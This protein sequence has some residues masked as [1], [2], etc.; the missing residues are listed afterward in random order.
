MNKVS[1]QESQSGTEKERAM[2]HF[3]ICYYCD[4]YSCG[5]QE[6]LNRSLAS[7]EQQKSSKRAAACKRLCKTGFQTSKRLT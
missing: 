2:Y 6:R 7:I 5:L 3:Y 1:T 4:K